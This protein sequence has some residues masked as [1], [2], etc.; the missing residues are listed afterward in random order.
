MTSLYTF[1]D[2]KEQLDCR[3]VIEE[4]LGPPLRHTGNSWVWACPFHDERTTGAFHGWRNGFKCFSCGEAGS[5]IDFVSVYLQITPAEAAVRLNGGENVQQPNPEEAAKRAAERAERAARE[6]EKRIE[7]AQE[8]LKELCQTQSWLRYHEQLTDD[9]RRLW[10]SWGIPD[11]FQGFWK[12][13]YD[14]DHVVWSGGVEWHTPTMTIPVFENYSWAC[15]NVRHRLMNPPMPGDK[16]RPERSGLPASFWIS[17]PDESL[18]GRAM[19]VEGEKKAAVTYITADDPRLNV[20]GLP[21]KNPPAQLLEKFSDCEPI[22]ICMD[23]DAERE[24]EKIAFAL[25]SERC[26]LVELPEKIDDMIL[27]HQLD[28]AWMRTI[29]RTARRLR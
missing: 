6:L 13:G 27:R 15:L 9:T 19:L 23:P 26:R 14:P 20:V 29:L 10:E 4:Y 16:Y 28:K 2:V 21:G 5:V 7:E 8:A 1:Q 11:F 22:Y 25:G 12:L 18:Q 3:Q 24:S 17:D